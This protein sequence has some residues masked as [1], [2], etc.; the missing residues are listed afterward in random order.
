[1]INRD[2][3]DRLRKN[4]ISPEARK[5][6]FEKLDAIYH[7]LFALSLIPWTSDFVGKVTLAQLHLYVLEGLEEFRESHQPP[8]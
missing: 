4:F 2:E 5:E 1:M 8:R 6:V 7:D 3:I